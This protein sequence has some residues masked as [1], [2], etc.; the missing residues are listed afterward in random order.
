MG[1]FLGIQL[2][3][4]T[5]RGNSEMTQDNSSKKRYGCK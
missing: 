5:K 2:E 1:I 4:W 3:Q